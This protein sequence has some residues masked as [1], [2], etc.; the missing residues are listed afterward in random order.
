MFNLYKDLCLRI[1]KEGSADKRYGL[2]FKADS[3]GASLVELAS[4]IITIINNLAFIRQL[5]ISTRPFIIIYLLYC[6]NL[7]LM[8]GNGLPSLFYL[9][10]SFF[11]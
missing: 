3:N 2:S 8:E 7:G 1:S 4:S 5:F 10:I 9:L 6:R 11:H